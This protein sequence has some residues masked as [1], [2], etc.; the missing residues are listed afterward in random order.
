M[1]S[2]PLPC[3]YAQPW[4]EA[5]HK[6]FL[7]SLEQFGNN[8]TGNEWTQMAQYVGTRTP[9]DIKLHAHKYFLKLQAATTSKHLEVDGGRA[10]M[11][12]HAGTAA[13]I[14]WTR[15]EDE[16]FESALAAFD[17]SLSDRWNHV[18]FPRGAF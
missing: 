5:E 4:T 3:R 1:P 8:Q 13:K 18:S 2:L 12:G 16:Q 11:G 15:E 14:Q 17:E 9:E 7:A 10:G 6:L